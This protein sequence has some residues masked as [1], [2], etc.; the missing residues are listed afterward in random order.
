MTERLKD[1][2]ALAE[3][4]LKKATSVQEA[5]VLRVQFLGK[6]GELTEI[7]KS[8]KD[9]APEQRKEMGRIAN[10]TKARIEELLS[11]RMNELKAAE[12]DAE[13]RAQTIDVTEPGILRRIGTL[14]P[15]LRQ[16]TK[17]QK[18]SLRWVFPLRKDRKLKRFII[19]LTLSMLRPITRQEISA[20]PFISR[21]MFC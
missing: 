8:M 10:E 11:A 17:S 20:I 3:E 6:K 16:S 19:T 15:I 12:R 13:L 5:E 18:Y 14:H 9:L 2:L 21:M 4:N 7:L 1:I